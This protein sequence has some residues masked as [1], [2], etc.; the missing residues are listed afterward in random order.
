M[1]IPFVPA[2]DNACRHIIAFKKLELDGYIHDSYILRNRKEIQYGER[3]SCLGR[4][5]WMQ[6]AYR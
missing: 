2:A 1:S 5:Q 6:T 4:Y 3:S